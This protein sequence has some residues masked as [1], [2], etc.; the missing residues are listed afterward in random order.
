M[1]GPWAR[2][3]LIASGVLVVAYAVAGALADPDTRPLGHLLFLA[4]V[5]IVHDGVLMP[6][7]IGIGLL[8][9]RITPTYGRPAVRFAALASISLALVGVPL[10]LRPGSA[11][12]SSGAPP[13]HGRDLLVVLI[14]VWAAALVYSCWRRRAPGPCRQEPSDTVRPTL[15]SRRTK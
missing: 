11:V 9:V 13:Q 2:R 1:T 6:L 12:E 4:G 3:L 7:A 15:P 10:V 14:I 8:I 5:L